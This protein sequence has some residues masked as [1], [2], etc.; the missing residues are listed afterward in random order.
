MNHPCLYVQTSATSITRGTFI[1]TEVSVCMHNCASITRL[2]SAVGMVILCKAQLPG[3]KGGRGS[4]V[5]FVATLNELDSHQLPS[6]PVL[7]QLGHAK[8]A[9][10]DVLDHLKLGIVD[11]HVDDLGRGGGCG[12]Q[13]WI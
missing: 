2:L 12:C 10:T 9:A 6:Q 11:V 7:H 8:I 4:L 5:Y 3:Q 1:D 13:F